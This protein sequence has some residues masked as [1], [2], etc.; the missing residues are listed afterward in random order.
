MDISHW[1]YLHGQPAW[2]A[3]FKQFPADFQV[4]EILGYDPLGE[5]EHIYLWVEKENLNTAFVAEQLAKFCKLPLRAISYAGR[6][7]KYALTRQW[8]GVHKPGKIDYD[9]SQWQLEGVKVLK[10]I[11]HNKKLRTGVLK[12]NTFAITLREVELLAKPEIEKRLQQIKVSGV[13]NYFGE[14]RFGS[15]K[16]A[17]QGANLVLAQ[18][19]I[20]GEEIRN[21]NKRSMAISALRSWLFNEFIHARLTAGKF[22]TPQQG[23]AMQLAGS[24]SFFI[25]EQVDETIQSRLKSGDIQITAP[26][27]GKGELPSQFDVN[28]QE[29]ALAGQHVQ[30]CQALESLGLEQERRAIHL[31]PQDMQWHWQDNDLVL[32]F[33]L[34][35][36]AFATSVLREVF[37]LI[38]SG[39]GDNENSAE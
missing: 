32:N 5:G 22:A 25:V 27:W 17:P 24:H 30:I 37:E 36:G 34:P 2:K 14:Q 33:S 10:A 31:A 6:K 3:T 1:H 13:P 19:M 28:V 8:F 4:T 18:K 20:E 16:Y 12:G 7:D 15:S 35:S 26:M 21:R 29:Q 39:D 9:W 23:D 38:T 11:R